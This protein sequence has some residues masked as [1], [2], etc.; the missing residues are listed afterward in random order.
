MKSRKVTFVYAIYSVQCVCVW[1][2]VCVNVFSSI[3]C[4]SLHMCALLHRVVGACACELN[5]KQAMMS[6]KNAGNMHALYVGGHR[7]KGMQTERQHMA[8]EQ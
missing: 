7:K 1:G 5:G 2:C 8:T 6:C 3:K 4:A